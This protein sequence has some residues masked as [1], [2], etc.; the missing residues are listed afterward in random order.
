MVTGA[1]TADLAVILV[2]ARN[3]VVEQ[4]RRHAYITTILRVPHITVAVNKMDLVEW[5]QDEFR[6]I[7]SDFHDLAWS[8]GFEQAVSIPVCGPSGDNIATRSTNMPWYT[9]ATLLQHLDSLPSRISDTHGPFR[10]AVQTVLRDGR[11]FRGL[12]GTITSGQ[13]KV[14][15]RIIDKLSGQSAKVARIVTMDRDLKA[16][17]VG[18]AVTI[19]PD[20][21]LDV[22]RGALIATPGAEPASASEIEAR[23][24]W[25]ADEGFDPKAGYLLR[26]ATDLVPISGF[27]IKGLIELETLETRPSSSCAVN[28]IAVAHLKLGRRIA[29]DLFASARDTGAVMIVDALTGATVAGGAVTVVVDRAVERPSSHAFRITRAALAGGVCRDLGTSEIDKEE[30]TRRA[31]EVAILLRSAGVAVALEI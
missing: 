14:G 17:T 3:G 23:L 8:C 22:A 30:F 1:S 26:T 19:Q 10:M 15:D 29:L 21:D 31:G 20:R 11:D 28:D 9:G 24:V 25:L 7:E 4:T 13:I 16:A 12:A 18:Q 6:A 5:S 2:D 27:E